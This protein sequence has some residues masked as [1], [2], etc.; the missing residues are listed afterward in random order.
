V[1][2]PC[3]ESIFPALPSIW[4]AV[5]TNSPT[6]RARSDADSSWSSLPWLLNSGHN[7]ESRCHAT[8]TP[9]RR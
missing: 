9:R 1:A 7:S 6:D 3:G 4:G 2:A 8:G 5:T